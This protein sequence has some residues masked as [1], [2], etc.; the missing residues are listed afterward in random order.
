MVVTTLA[1]LKGVVAEYSQYPEFVLDIETVYHP[2]PDEQERHE[3]VKATPVNKRNVDDRKWI[4][5][6]ELKA[7]DPLVNEI[8]WI[9]FAGP[10]GSAVAIPTGHPKGRQTKPAR[11]IKMQACDVFPEGDARG[12]TRGG[13]PSKRA[14][15][16]NFPAEFEPPP[17]QLS[18]EVVI[19]ELRP[20]FFGDHL[21]VGQNTKFDIKTFV[22][23]FD[24]EWPTCR[25]ADLI[26]AQH[27]LEERLKDYGLEKLTM[28]HFKKTYDKLGKKGVHNYSWGQAARYTMQDCRY[29]WLLWVK[30]KNRL[31]R[32]PS[33]WQFFDDYAIPFNDAIMKMEYEGVEVDTKQVA[34]LRVLREKQIAQT[35]DKLIVDYGAPAD[36]NPNAGAQKRTLLF[37][38]Y[39]GKAT[40]ITKVTGMPSVDADSLQA[41]ADSVKR[42]RDPETGVVTEIPHP[43]APVAQLLLDYADQNKIL[44]TYLVGIPNRLDKQRRVH[45]DYLLHGTETSRLCV[46]P[47]TLI[48]M[49]RDLQRYPDGI[50]LHMINVGDMVYTYTWD[51]KLAIRPVLWVGPT[52]VSRTVTLEIIDSRTGKHTE[53]CCSPDHLVRMYN[54]DWRAAGK[55]KP[56][57][58]LMGMVHRG[59]TDEGRSYFFPSS[60]R[61]SRGESGGKAFEHRWVWGQLNGY[62]AM[63]SQWDIHHEDENKIN[64]HPS[65]LTKIMHPEHVR[66]HKQKTTS[67]AV[68]MMLD[69][70]ELTVH[71]KTLKR[72]AKEYGLGPS[73]HT[74]VSVRQGPPKQLWDMEVEDTHTFIGQ[75]VALHNSCREPNI[76]NIP[77]ESEMRGMFVAPKGYVFVIGDYD[78]IEL[79]KI[80]VE[81]RDPALMYLFNSGQDVHRGTAAMVLAQEFDETDDEERQIYGKMPNFLVGYG[82][83]ATNLAEKTGIAE[84]H[85]QKVIDL[86]FKRFA[87]IQ[88]WKDEVIREARMRARFDSDR[89][90]IRKPYVETMLGRRRRLPELFSDSKKARMSAERKAVNTIIQGGASETTLLA[91]V[92]VTKYKE[93]EHFPINLVINVH[94]ELVATVP[95]HLEEEG[96]M[97]LGELMRG[98]VVPHT[99]ELPLK[100]LVPLAAKVVSNDKWL[101]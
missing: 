29:E 60:K 84:K 63:P 27:I 101:K 64:Q 66:M 100:G 70:G 91:M 41:V 30:L 75:D 37:G 81:A 47:T 73:N 65:N 39:K 87:R 98:V 57:H 22:K 55:L 9:G 85:A 11:K 50:P 4:E 56:G 59:F 69:G 99:G 3:R 51:K 67:E 16:V 83:G 94:D 17:E 86:W 72:L 38:K 58:R 92:A 2:T 93:R 13:L 46:D 12:M 15:L 5:I 71:P 78:Q 8:N 82:G 97:I 7:T 96:K 32:V 33:L 49:P 88:P 14:V 74:V 95:A 26:H 36:F 90:M 35:V 6:F 48:E 24:G 89:N 23:Y 34:E 68:Q 77:R 21:I 10:G 1:A 28:R 42:V 31:Q 40:N 44:S 61:R 45:A 52:K 53:L 20:L 54:G 43:A 18:I 80:S 25:V 76:Q 62:E 19:R 79:R